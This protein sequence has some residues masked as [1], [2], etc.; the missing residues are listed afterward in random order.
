MGIGVIFMVDA[1]VEYG[2]LNFR[3]A[4]FIT[5]TA[6]ASRVDVKKVVRG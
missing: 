4:C 1:I 2:A 3:G 5:R 6:E